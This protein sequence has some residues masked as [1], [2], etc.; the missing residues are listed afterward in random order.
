MKFAFRIFGEDGGQLALTKFLVV[1]DGA[2]VELRD[3]RQV[4]EYVLA[5]ARF[6]TDLF[7][8]ATSPWTPSTTRGRP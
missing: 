4:L 8:I 7:V 5:R 6:E 2:G 1:L 3:F